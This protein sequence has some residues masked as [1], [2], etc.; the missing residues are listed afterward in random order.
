VGEQIAYV[1]LFVHTDVAAVV[2]L[3]GVK[4]PALDEPLSQHQSRTGAL[5]IWKWQALAFHHC[6][7]SIAHLGSAR[8][9]IGRFAL[10]SKCE[11]N[12]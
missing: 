2:K 11:Y 4:I 9:A 10:S 1:Q 7:T 3:A 5:C 12:M 6:G 8:Q